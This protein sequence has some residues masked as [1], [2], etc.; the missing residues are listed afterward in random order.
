MTTIGRV[1]K[2]ELIGP[3]CS[4]KSTFLNEVEESCR[5]S[6]KWTT[7][8]SGQHGLIVRRAK[9]PIPEEGVKKYDRKC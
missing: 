6:K 4:G 1:F 5:R 9:V 3:S 2:L 7:V 8:R